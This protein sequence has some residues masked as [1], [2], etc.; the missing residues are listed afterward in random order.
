MNPLR[1][2]ALV[3]RWLAT[4][5][6]PSWLISWQRKFLMTGLRSTR[7][8]VECIPM[9]L[10]SVPSSMTWH[11]RAESRHTTLV[12]WSLQLTALPELMPAAQVQ[13]PLWAASMHGPREMML[14]HERPATADS[15]MSSL[16]GSAI[17]PTAPITHD[18]E[19]RFQHH[20]V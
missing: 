1:V 6:A 12:K 9:M 19:R 14:S 20:D 18:D 10:C 15:C 8:C 17:T 2:H 4:E 16:S 7:F 13:P 11:L 5:L 3:H